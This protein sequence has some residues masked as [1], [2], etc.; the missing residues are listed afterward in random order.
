MNQLLSLA[1]LKER[2]QLS[3]STL[4]RLIESGRIRSCK[5]Y[6]GKMKQRAPIRVSEQALGDFIAECEG[7]AGK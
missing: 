7:G 5:I 2:T 1:N 3:R 4:I 6:N